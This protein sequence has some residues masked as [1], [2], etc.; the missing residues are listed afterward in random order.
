MRFW[1]NQKLGTIASIKKKHRIPL[2]LHSGEWSQ[3]KSWKAIKITEWNVE[4]HIEMNI[5]WNTSFG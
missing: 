2:V 3:L 5:D 1:Y 4:S